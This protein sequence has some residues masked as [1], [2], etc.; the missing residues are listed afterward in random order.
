[1][2]M[3]TSQHNKTIRQ[4]IRQRRQ[5]LTALEQQ[6]AATDLVTQFA[7]H[8][9]FCAARD[10]AIYL[11]NDGELNTQPLIEWLWSAGKTVYLPVMH[12]FQSG[13]LLFQ[14]YQISTPM[15]INRF[16]IA[17][18]KL[19]CSAICPV[20]QL[21]LICLPLVAFDDKCHRLGMGGG[22]YDRTLSQLSQLSPASGRLA[23]PILLGL[24][25]PCQQVE[26]LPQQPWD[27]P[28]DAI[29]TPTKRW[30]AV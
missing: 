13:Y 26:S 4:H 2:K 17:E 29:L 9:D 8:A 25:H 10:I 5:A 30:S 19:D 6:Q 14:R 16:G 24:A 15:H 12:P 11:T 18:P 7:N 22:F 21:S 28:L 3:L 20:A 1:M 23:K 27:V